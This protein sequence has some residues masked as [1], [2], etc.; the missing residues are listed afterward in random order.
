MKI[1]HIGHS[2]F[3]V[4]TASALLLFDYHRGDLSIIDRAPADKPLFVFVSHAHGDHFNPDIFALSKGARKVKY[5]LSFDIKGKPAVP[6]NA[7]ALYA[8]ADKEYP[9]PG[10]GS[11]VT[12]ASTDEGVA[13]LVR[14]PDATV[15]H[16]GDLNFWDWEGEDDAWLLEQETVFRRETAKLAGIEIDAAFVVLDDR[17][18]GNFAEGML[19][20]LD[21]CRASHVFPMH[22]WKDK[23]VIERLLQMPP[24]RKSDAVIHDTV[25]EKHW[26]I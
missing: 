25:N 6:R 10:L 4:E 13:F 22:F 3:L 18:E 24:A 15:F 11:V 17:L 1:D 19:I 26:E 20:F 8:Y 16:A 23:T 5:I 12:F 21:T 2:G 7:D 9:V 14:T